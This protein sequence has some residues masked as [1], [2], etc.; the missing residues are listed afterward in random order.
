MCCTFGD[1]TDIEWWKKYN[2]PL[3]NIFTNDGKII[4][5]IPKYGKL[6][7][8]DARK[9][10]IQDLIEQNYLI[11]S[12]DLEHEV[13]V[14]ERC[15][16]EVEYSVMKQWF[17]DIMNH[18]QDFLKIGEEISWYPKHMKSRYDEWV[19]NI[20]WD[21]C[22]S[23]QRYFG[24]AF[25]VW[26][27]KDCGKV[28]LADKKDLP[29][30]P[31]VDKPNIDKCP[32]CNCSEFIPETDIMDTWQTSSIT[33]LINMKYGEKD[34]YEDIL[35]TM[36]L[37][38]NAHDIIRTWDFYS[39][40]KGYYGF[41][42]KPWENIMISGFVM[43]NKGEKISKSKNNS[44]MEP[45]DLLNEYGADIVRYWAG[46]G[47]LGTDIIFSEETFLRG[48][49]LLNKIWNVSKFIEMHLSDY[50]DKDFNDYEYI[51]KWIIAK[52]QEMEKQFIKYL[53]NYEIGLG[54]NIL[55]KFFWEFCDN[56]IEIVNHRLY[57]PE[58][59]GEIPRYS[60]QKTVYT[61]L[62]KLLQNFSIYFPYIT[63]EIYQE[64]YKQEKSIHITTIKTLN[65]NFND[66]L[67][68]GDMIC[69]IIGI[70]RGQKS[71]NNLSLKT[72]VSKLSISAE[73]KLIDAINSSIKDFKATLFINDLNLNEQE[74]DYKIDEVIL[75]EQ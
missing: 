61:L 25:P 16:K 29:V 56:Y 53:D 62:Y 17:I 39:I 75:N 57:R 45:F 8:K 67:K 70:I 40:V 14:H 4:E 44:K 20:M 23:R 42:Q 74:K 24:V 66:E 68:Y 7:I 22:I 59:F 73:T 71:I 50:E 30:N 26:Y 12:E 6:P 9:E 64:L 18:K 32:N 65:Y 47:K 34:N 54:L 69:D 36:S 52:Y 60:G 13:Q 3:K 49:K 43:A 41:K 37:R 5:T 46:S 35:K 11:K 51:D 15:G 2:L 19:E 10:I 27:C 38:C 33:P 58:E 31:L 21:W 48:K 55:E 72:E 63:E 28:I 1:Q